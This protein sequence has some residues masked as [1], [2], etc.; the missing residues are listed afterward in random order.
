[1]AIDHQV[2]VVVV[3]GDHH[4]DRRLLPALSQRR[5]QMAL[6]VRLT[7]SQVFPSQV[8][9]V[10]L[11]VHGRVAESDWSPLWG[12]QPEYAAGRDWSFAEAGEV[13]RELLLDQ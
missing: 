6:A 9:R 10:K 12:P 4:D 2:A 8:E 13:C 5:Q 7:D 3:F 11:Q 1:M